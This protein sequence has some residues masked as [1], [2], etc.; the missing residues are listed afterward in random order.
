[1]DKILSSIDVISDYGFQLSLQGCT[2][3]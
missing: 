2:E 1:V 3:K